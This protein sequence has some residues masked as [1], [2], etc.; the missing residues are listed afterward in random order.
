MKRTKFF[1]LLILGLILSSVNVWADTEWVPD[2]PFYVD[3]IEECVINEREYRANGPNGK[4]IIYESPASSKVMGTM[5]NGEIVQIDFVYTNAQKIEWGFCDYHGQIGWIPM[6]YMA[7][8]YDYLSFEAEYGDQI[9]N[10]K[11]KVEVDSWTFF[12]TDC[13]IEFWTY[14]GSERGYTIVVDRWRQALPEY[15]KTFVDEDGRK[16]GFVGYFLGDTLNRWICLESQEELLADYDELYPNGGPQRDKIIVEA[17]TGE[18][19]FPDDYEIVQ[20]ELEKMQKEQEVKEKLMIV[21][22]V[23]FVVAALIFYWMLWKK[24]KRA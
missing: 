17:Y 5:E 15:K 4:A 9:Q 23:V 16:W 22:I 1:V 3:H 18:E 20:K 21:G 7:L 6:P 13:G 11:G 2:D 14:P 12:D 10:E 24:I 8:V 19:I